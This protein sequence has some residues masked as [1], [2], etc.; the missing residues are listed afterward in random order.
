MPDIVFESVNTPKTMPTPS[1]MPTAVSSVRCAL[2]RRLRR[3]R[4]EKRLNFTGT[5]PRGVL[6]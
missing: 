4:P 6:T 2:A 5:P 1:T 3:L